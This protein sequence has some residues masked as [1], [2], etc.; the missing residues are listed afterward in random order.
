M[1]RIYASIV[2]LVSFLVMSGCA[3]I[4]AQST[5]INKKT[6]S[7]DSALQ[8]YTTLGLQYMQSGDTVNAKTAVQKALDINPDYGPA[9]NALALIFQVEGEMA[10][11]EQYFKK[12]I[13]LEPDSAMFHNNYGAF[14][15][16]E[17]RFKEACAELAKATQDPFYNRRAKAFEN[18]GRCYTRLDQTDPAIFAF[19]RALRLGGI[20]PV[21]L[22][23]LADLHLKQSQYAE[24]ENYYRQFVDLVN[25]K[26]LKHSSKSLWVGIKLARINSKS[27]TAAT[28]A[29]LL[30][31]LYPESEEYKAYKESAR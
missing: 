10:L 7:S 23:E 29:L 31:N 3:G 16:S 9:F 15:F 12:A 27:S 14:L 4:G 18:L 1:K 24:A 21:A 17:E 13:S 26:K 5:A 22:V 20:Q 19:E 25:S 6:V 28:Y 11:T 30:K 8:A 2:L